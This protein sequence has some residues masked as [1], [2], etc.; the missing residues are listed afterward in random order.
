MS[1]CLEQSGVTVP[2]RHEDGVPG[3]EHSSLN[4]QSEI[5]AGHNRMTELNARRIAATILDGFNRHYRIFLEITGQARQRFEACDWRGQRQAA[6]DRINLYTQRVSEATERLKAEFR[7][8]SDVDEDLWRGQAALYRLALR[9]QAARTRGRPSTT[10]CSP[11][12]PPPL[13]QQRQHLRAS[14][15]VDRVSGRR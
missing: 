2:A 11:G 3:T 5:L 1:K 7:L 15:S 4:L 9:T 14:R 8:D 6:S 10:P 13:L 12:F